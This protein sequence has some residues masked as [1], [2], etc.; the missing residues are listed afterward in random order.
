V[1]VVADAL[2]T[3]TYNESCDTNYYHDQ[4]LE[5]QQPS[6]DGTTA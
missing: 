5:N 1:D 6:Q 3:A 4:R 2:Y